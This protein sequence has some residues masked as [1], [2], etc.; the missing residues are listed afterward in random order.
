MDIAGLRG[1]VRRQP[2]QPF[3]IRLADGRSMA[4]PHS[5]FVAVGNRRVIVVGENDSWSVIEP[6]LIVSLD[7]DVGLTMT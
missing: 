6:I 1:A 5:E 7:Y 3:T 2:F 4:V